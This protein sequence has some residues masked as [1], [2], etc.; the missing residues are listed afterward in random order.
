MEKKKKLAN[1]LAMSCSTFGV[2]RPEMVRL[3]RSWSPRPQGQPQVIGDAGNLNA[4]LLAFEYQ[5]VVS[6][7][8]RWEVEQR[9]KR[10]ADK[11]TEEWEAGE[12]VPAGGTPSEDD[13]PF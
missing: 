4:E 2:T 7:F 13:I 5:Q 12:A 6:G 11:A 9:A 3:V 1:A 8:K 10:T